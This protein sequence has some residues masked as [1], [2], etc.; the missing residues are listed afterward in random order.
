VVGVVVTGRVLGERPY[1][2]GLSDLG[3]GGDFH[4]TLVQ[5]EPIR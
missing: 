3:G 5:V 4:D 1:P 2:D